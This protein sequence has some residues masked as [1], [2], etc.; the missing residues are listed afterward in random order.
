MRQ[1]FLI[2]VLSSLL[3]L[4]SAVSF[5]LRAV[6]A[7]NAETGKRCLSIFAPKNVQMLAAVKVE[8]G[9]NQR[10]NV[11]I[12]D[13]SEPPNEYLNKRDISSDLRFVFDTHATGIVAICF[14]NI[15]EN[16]KS[17][18]TIYRIDSV[19]LGFHEDPLY[20]RSVELEFSVGA[21]AKDYDKI[22]KDE[23]LGP[24]ELELRKLETVVNEIVEDMGYLQRREAKLRDT[25][26]STN[27]RVKG[28]SI[29]SLFTL[30]GLGTWQI[31]Y[32]RQYF[33]RKRLID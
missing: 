15:L 10:V 28:F 4:A 12:K 16:G 13:D 17:Y 6:T 32:L 18:K 30:V 27:A 2:V 14:T 20:R 33:R 23:K 8:P 24:L 1:T 7:N 3:A 25:N 29:L 31:L 9:H 21:E 22:A 19:S 5:D 11:E 26:E